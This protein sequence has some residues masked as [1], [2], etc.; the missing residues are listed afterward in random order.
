MI[1]TGGIQL[2]GATPNNTG[3]SFNGTNQYLI[4]ASGA[5]TFGSGD[6]TVECWFYK[7]SATTCTLVG[8]ATGNSDNNYWYLGTNAN[9]TIAFGIRDSAA[10]GVAI[11]GSIIT[12]INT[13][14]HVAAVRVSGTVK[15]FVNGVLDTS[16]TIAKSITARTTNIGSFLYNGFL[17]FFP[18]YISNLRLV[19]GAGIYTGNF[20]VPT[21]PFG[22]TQSANPFGGANTSAITGSQTSLLLTNSLNDSSVNNYTITNQNTVSSVNVELPFV[23]NKLQISL[24]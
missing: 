5:S 2:T 4:A 18:G 22:S 9:G 17:D 23:Y 3:A 13:W 20:T 8:N 15:L 11:T 10:A 24:L 19:T 1:L 14:V 6:F 21:G 12:S 7:T 16:G